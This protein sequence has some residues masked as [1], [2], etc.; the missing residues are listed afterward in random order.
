MSSTEIQNL[1][2]R[3]PQLVPGVQEVGV[4]L[5]AGGVGREGVSL[6]LE[7]VELRPLPHLV[8]VEGEGEGVP[9]FWNLAPGFSP[10]PT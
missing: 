10:F 4:G 8:P 9:P 6:G 5:D 3:D 7:E 1:S 2:G